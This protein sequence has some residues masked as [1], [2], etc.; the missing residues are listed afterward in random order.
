MKRPSSLHDSSKGGVSFAASRPQQAKIGFNPNT[1]CVD[2]LIV[3]GY[4]VDVINSINTSSNLERE[5]EKYFKEVDTTVDSAVLSPVRD[6]RED[7]KWKVPI[8][9]VLY[10]KVAVSGGLDLRSSYA[11]LRSYINGNQKGKGIEENGDSVNGTAHSTAYA[12][13]VEQMS[14]D[15]FQKQSASYIAALQGTL[16]GWRFVVTK[17][18]FV[19][20][21]PNM[22]RIGDVVAILKGGRVPFI[23]QKSVA[24]PGSFRLVG[25]CYIHCMMNG[26]GLSLP[27]VV[28]SDFR[29]H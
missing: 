11:A 12:M 7:M 6:S 27:G 25:E 15:P 29:L 2:E 18:G 24:R 26:E 1:D 19:G 23:V 17:G 9:G 16:S 22:A 3:E 10:P 14:A 8:A 13:A 20:V 4:E 21:V 28:E 5:W